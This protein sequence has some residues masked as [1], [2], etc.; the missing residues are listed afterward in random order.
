M[1]NFILSEIESSTKKYPH[2]FYI[3]FPLGE[4]WLT[5]SEIENDKFGINLIV[6]VIKK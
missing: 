6:N 4:I 2:Q 5:K 3:D 1:K